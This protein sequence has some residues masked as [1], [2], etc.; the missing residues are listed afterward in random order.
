MKSLLANETRPI[1]QLLRE[2]GVISDE[3]LNNALSLQK[4]RSDKLGRILVD[5]GYVAE[6]DV[7]SVLSE[8]LK[9]EIFAGDYPAVPIETSKLPMRFLRNFR[10]LPVHLEN[11]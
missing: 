3:D 10:A 1:G 8:Q 9:I 4:E 11:N 7:L 6:R 5:L 2:R